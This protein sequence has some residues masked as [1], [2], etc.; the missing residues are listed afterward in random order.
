MKKLLISALFISGL[1]IAQAQNIKTPAPS[2]SQNVK[3]EFGLGSIEL[4]YSRPAMKGRKIFGDLVPYNAVWRTGANAGTTLTF[5]D[6]VII[7]GTKVPAGKY[8]LLTIPGASEWTIIISKQTDVTSPAAYKQ[9][10]DVVRVKATPVTMPFEIESFTIMFSN[11]KANSL[12]LGMMWD[13]SYV[14]LPITT[15]VESKVM[16]QIDAAMNKDNKPYFQSAMYY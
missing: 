11:V 10:Q 16:A 3:Q 13:K 2:P 15:D 6:E 8:G 7:G 4:S 1:M 5:S 14:P 12:E 9:D